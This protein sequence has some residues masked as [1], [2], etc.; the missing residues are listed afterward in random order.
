MANPVKPIQ[1]TQFKAADFQDE[2]LGYFNNV[3]SQMAN[4]INAGNG[5]TGK[6]KLPAGIDVAGSTVSGVGEPQTPTDAVS[7][8]HA[9]RN[10]SAAAL[11]PK[12][13]AGGSHSL[14]TMRR[15]SDTNQQ[16]TNS[17][18]LQRLSNT[19]P[20]S[21]TSV[22][23]G[24]TGGG[25]TTITVPS[26]FHQYPDGTT[27]PFATATLTV[28]NPVVQTITGMTR[29]GGV[30]TATGA[31]SGL[32]PGEAIFVSGATDPSFDG[33]FS[34]VTAGGSTITWNQPGLP[35]VIIPVTGGS[36]STSGVYYF[37]LEYPSQTLAVDAGPSGLGYPSDTQ[38]NRLNSNRDGRVLIAVAVVSGGGLVEE[39]SA[40]GATPPVATNGNRIISR[41]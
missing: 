35:D 32:T 31:F 8:S 14:K 18:Y 25:S 12:L 11:A 39:Q 21:T 24:S 33:T 40:G 38:Q 37:F 10:Y 34:L 36:I 20:T 19:T 9:E 13:E 22:V 29:S 23:T 1:F 27:K 30:T 2:N 17:V 26:G 7:K 3:M 28:P 6:T 41:L 5:A 16:E 4:A 15:L